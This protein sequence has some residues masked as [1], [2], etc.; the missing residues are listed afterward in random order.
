MSKIDPIVK[1]GLFG[2]GYGAASGVI[3]QC[4]V[5][6]AIAAAA[7]TAGAVAASCATGTAI[8]ILPYFL[9][10][11][12][13]DKVIDKNENP[14]TH[15]ILRAALDVG[16]AVS[17]ALVGAAIIGLAATPIMYCALAG[18]AALKLAEVCFKA[19]MGCICAAATIKVVA[20]NLSP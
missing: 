15:W 7:G 12:G 9:L 3:G 18:V 10:R 19:L 17:A 16:L 4:F 1:K 11:H 8:L 13:L 20:N 14:L 6:T 2:V 5:P